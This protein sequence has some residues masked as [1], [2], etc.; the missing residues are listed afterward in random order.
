MDGAF[1]PMELPRE[2]VTEEASSPPGRLRSAC[3]RVVAPN[4]QVLCVSRKDGRGWCLPGGKVEEGETMVFGAQREL[5]EETGLSLDWSRLRLVYAGD[6][7]G[8]SGRREVACFEVESASLPSFK[9]GASPE[10]L[11][12][13]WLEWGALVRESPFREFY[14]RCG[15]PAE[16]VGPHSEKTPVQP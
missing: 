3:V 14:E 9:L 4:G 13:V 8:L 11:D 16:S 5:Y 15:A 6:Y 1:P 2:P 7:R 10:G 12:M